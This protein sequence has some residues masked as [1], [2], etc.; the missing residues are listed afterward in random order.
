MPCDNCPISYHLV[1][2]DLVVIG[3]KHAVAQFGFVA[4][5]WQHAMERQAETHAAAKCLHRRLTRKK[6][7]H[8]IS[9]LRDP[10]GRQTAGNQESTK[11]FS[12]SSG[13]AL[14]RPRSQSGTCTR[15]RQPGGTLFA[16]RAARPT[17]VVA[18]SEVDRPLVRGA[19]VDEIVEYQK[20]ISDT[21][22]ESLGVR[23][24]PR[25]GSS[26]H[27][28]AW[29]PRGFAVVGRVRPRIA[30]SRILTRV[31]ARPTLRRRNPGLS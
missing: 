18:C 16:Q 5:I 23:L 21:A 15:E 11:A 1:L 19:H 22:V 7:I 24:A 26:H 13:V 4:S 29:P 3:A 12:V 31:Y 27:R 6:R 2:L 8:Q 28:A 20:L 17:V 25:T 10:S 14:E 9:R 30:G